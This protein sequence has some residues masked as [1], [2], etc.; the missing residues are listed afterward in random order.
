MAISNAPMGMMFQACG[1]N[2]T[3]YWTSPLAG[4]YQ[5]KAVV[6][7][8]AGGSAQALVPVTVSAR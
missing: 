2:I 1:L 5:L 7:D 3:A 6:T 8:P 4:S